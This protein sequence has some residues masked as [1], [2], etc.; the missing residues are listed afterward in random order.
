MRDRS[1]KILEAAVQGFIDYGEPV[2]SGWLY[3]RHNFGIRPAMI[4][5]ELEKLSDEGFL[6]QPYHSAGRVPSD[7]GYEF[8]A[9]SILEKDDR[10]SGDC[11]NILEFFAN[12]SR[13]DFL[14][15]FSEDLGLLGVLEERGEV[16]KT[17]IEKLFDNLEEETLAEAKSMICDFAE[18]DERL[19]GAQKTLT[20]EAGPMV[21]IGKKSPVTN[22]KSLAVVSACYHDNGTEILLVGVGHK[23]MDY[24]KTLGVFRELYER[25]GKTK[26]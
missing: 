24:K 16:H 14:E 26:R 17:G 18:I 5:L 22:S 12:K 9:E 2:S 21:F 7:K 11:A 1:A 10:Y 6:E 15:R 4:R 3:S 25:T 13:E 8:F 19:R 23:R 20:R